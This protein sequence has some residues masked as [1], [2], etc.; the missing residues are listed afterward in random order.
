[1][2]L[3]K[4]RSRS[5]R[6]LG[7]VLAAGPVFAAGMVSAQ[8]L[9]WMNTAL[10]PEQRASLLVGAMTLDQKIAQLH[11]AT[12]GPPEIPQ[13][14]TNNIRQVPAIASLQIPTFRITNGPVGIGGGDCNPQDP[15]T[16]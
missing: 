11:G 10:P 2:R 7:C 4:L 16:A 5:L 14:G 6:A 1:N 8:T 3:Q 9:P 15:A 13:C 12:G